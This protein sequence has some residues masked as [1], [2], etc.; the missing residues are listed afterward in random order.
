MPRGTRRFPSLVVGTL[1]LALVLLLSACDDDGA[2]DA[3]DAPTATEPI[4][5]TFMAGFRP[6]ANLPFVAAYMAQE[7]GYFTDESLDV[8][9]RH[10]GQGE[11]LQL[12]L[13][14]EIDVT[15]G[16]AAQVLRRRATDLPVRAVALFGQRGDQGFVA[17]AGSGIESPADFAGRRVGFKSGV[18]PAELHALLAGAGLTVDDIELQ[19]VGFDPRVFMEGEVDIYPVFLGNEPDTIR[20]AGFEITVFDP[21]EFAV[22]TLGLTYLVTDETATESREML[23]RFVRAAMRGAQYAIA[24]PDEAVAVV[25]SYAEGADAEHQRFLLDTDITNATR[26]DVD[27]GGV[28]ELGRADLAQW[29]ALHDLLR[30]FEILET[31]VD[32][33]AVWDARFIDAVYAE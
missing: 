12:L 29:Q 5:M 17:R 9:I 8:T 23:Q 18:V 22:P 6:Q 11:H 20:R 16:T 13:A 25:L 19:G 33:E 28:G 2:G 31:D 15:T 14:G 27:A 21:A 32:V 4:A 1:L 26:G 7:R 30:R 10:A 24:H 3:T